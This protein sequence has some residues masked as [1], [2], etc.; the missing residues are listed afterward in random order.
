MK[1]TIKSIENQKFTDFEIILIYDNNEK[2]DLNNIKHFIKKF[3]NIK[4]INNSKKR[5]IIYSLS[6]G[7]ISSRGKYILILQSCYTLSKKN[8]LKN[9]YNIINKED[10]DI[11]E[12]D[13]L[14][15]KNEEINKNSLNLYKCLHYKSNINLTLIK[16]NKNY[17]EIDQENEILFN[18]LIKAHIFKNIIIEYNFANYTN[19]VYNYF[20]NIFLFSLFKKKVKFQHYNIIGLIQSFNII[21]LKLNYIMNKKK[22]KFKDS[23]FYINFLYDQTGN[24]FREKKLAVEQYFNILSSIYN[25]FQLIT[26]ESYKL[27]Q[28]FMKSKYINNFDKNNLIFYYNSLIN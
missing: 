27:F 18:K 23:I 7:V 5:G 16:Y 4:L 22:Q 6:I 14:I 24:S 25:K 9:I 12:F 28:K 20:H 2:E 26:K 13:L 10:L 11:L 3:K 1:K 17:K 8:I 21:N 15:S 19:V